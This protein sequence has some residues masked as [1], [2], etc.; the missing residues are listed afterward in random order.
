MLT[1]RHLIL[2]SHGVSKIWYCSNHRLQ[3]CANPCHPWGSHSPKGRGNWK[4]TWERGLHWH[5]TKISRFYL[6]GH[7]ER[8]HPHASWSLNKRLT[9]DPF[10]Q[11][12]SQRYSKVY[13]A[14]RRPLTF[15]E[16]AFISKKIERCTEGICRG[17]HSS[18]RPSW[19]SLVCVAPLYTTKTTLGTKSQAWHLSEGPVMVIGMPTQGFLMNTWSMQHSQWA[20]QQ[21]QRRSWC[22]WEKTYIS[23]CLLAS[24]THSRRLIWRTT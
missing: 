20:L 10:I 11:C 8:A 4:G 2:P 19:P 5:E 14:P 16:M 22:L 12:S 17:R 21:Q 18:C 3:N 23:K 9:K 7:G 1:S 24:K 6:G 13:P 15:L